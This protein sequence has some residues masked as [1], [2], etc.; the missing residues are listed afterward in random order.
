MV[1]TTTTTTTTTVAPI[2][3][4]KQNLLKPWFLSGGT[5][6]PSNFQ[7]IPKLFPDEDDGDRIVEQL[8]YVPEN[9]QGIYNNNNNNTVKALND[10]HTVKVL[11]ETY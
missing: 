10:S 9:Y 7:G 5:E 1:I 4:T 8:M 6:Y 2:Q 11:K 3:E